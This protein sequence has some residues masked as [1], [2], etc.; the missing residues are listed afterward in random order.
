MTSI[1]LTLACG[2]Y[3]RIAGLADGR[4][5]AQ[6]VDL[7][8]VQLEPEEIFLRMLR[9]NEFDASEMSFS[10]FAI[11]HS[12]GDRRLVGI[13]VFLSRSFRHSTI[14]LRADSDIRDANDL[15]GRRVG[16]P[17][18]QMTASVW[19]R[20]LLKDEYGI[21]AG[22]VTWVTGGMEQPGRAERQALT[23]PEHIRT[24]RIV[25]STL[26]EGLLDGSIDALMAPRVPAVFRQPDSPI[27][28]LW[29]DYAERERDYFAR[30][31]LFPIMHIVAM[32]TDVFDKD[33]WL[34]Q[35]I[36]KA[37]EAAK[38]LALQGA[39]DAPALRWT[40][41][42]ML[43]A[44]ERDRDLFG[45]DPWPYGLESNR[46]TVEVF[47]RYLREQGLVHTE[48]TPESL[49]VPSTHTEVRI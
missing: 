45:G 17:E 22:D 5:R 38:Q 11:A 27:R 29:P 4:V 26:V 24:E 44:L 35:E 13:P 25:D 32:R 47:I 34:A 12:K 40:L 31:G 20:G 9:H 23:L 16:V 10:S 28:R 19:T 39:E 8:V 36:A 15:A 1:P 6:G 41:P 30:T 21:D 3:D 48:L 43:D 14:Y 46:A 33:P 49:F 2:P 18:Y 7:N 42:F 37:F